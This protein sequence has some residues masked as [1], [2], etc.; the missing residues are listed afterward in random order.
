MILKTEI[1][2]VDSNETMKCL[3]NESLHLTKF[4]GVSCSAFRGLNAV[5]YLAR[6]VYKARHLN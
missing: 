1:L 5:K 4:D 2:H 3:L 6:V